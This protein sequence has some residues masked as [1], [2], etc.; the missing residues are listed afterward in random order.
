M[1][2]RNLMSH[3]WICDFRALKR[4]GDFFLR[5]LRQ[6]GGVSWVDVNCWLIL[7]LFLSF[8]FFFFLFILKIPSKMNGKPALWQSYAYANFAF[9]IVPPFLAHICFI[10]PIPTSGLQASWGLEDSTYSTLTALESPDCLEPWPPQNRKMNSRSWTTKWQ[11]YLPISNS[12]KWTRHHR[13]HTF[14]NW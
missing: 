10:I 1:C 7:P 2:T 4:A 11:Q 12:I 5:R 14:R 6:P 9:S 8:S 13:V 3:F